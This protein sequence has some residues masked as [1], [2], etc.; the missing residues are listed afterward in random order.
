MTADARDFVPAK[1]ILDT[2]QMRQRRALT[3]HSGSGSL[4]DRGWGYDPRIGPGRL[5]LLNATRTT[6]TAGTARLTLDVE[7]DGLVKRG[8]R[9]CGGRRCLCN[10][11]LAN[12]IGSG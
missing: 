4:I 9:V 10:P 5:R 8:V 1:R 7:A 12:A 3:A 2:I 6:A 11:L